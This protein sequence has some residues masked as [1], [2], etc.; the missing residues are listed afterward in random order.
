MSGIK[1]V[2]WMWEYGVYIPFCPYCG[3]P[4]YE[5]DSCYF[6]GKPYKYVEG[7]YKP[8]E[9]QCGEY[10]VVQNTNNH[11]HIYKDDSMVMHIQCTVKK[12]EEE[13]SIF[14]DIYHDTAGLQPVDRERAF[15]AWKLL[16][17]E[18]RF[19]AVGNMIPYLSLFKYKCNSAADYL[20]YKCFN[21]SE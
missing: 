13:F 4:A 12:T 18:E 3:E 21:M 14:W 6:C 17:K 10:T 9:V 5:K 20:T 15:R 2:E 1:E 7:E 11:I 19:L 16:D 8:T